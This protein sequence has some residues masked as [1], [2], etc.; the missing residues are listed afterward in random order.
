LQ[1]NKGENLPTARKS[2]FA[3]PGRSFQIYLVSERVT[4]NPE[5]TL[6][7]LTR[8]LLPAV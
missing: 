1:C 8:S 6:E 4:V 2:Y 5:I 7:L 3:N